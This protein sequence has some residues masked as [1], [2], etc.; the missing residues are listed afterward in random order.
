MVSLELIKIAVLSDAEGYALPF[1]LVANPIRCLHIYNGIM[2]VRWRSFR[3]S[4]C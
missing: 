1:A 3:G 4:C 2:T